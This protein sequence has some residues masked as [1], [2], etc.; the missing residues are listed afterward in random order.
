MVL[1]R[2]W[3]ANSVLA[4]HGPKDS[5][6]SCT[7]VLGVYSLNPAIEG[8][9]TQLLPATQPAPQQALPAQKYVVSS[10]S[11]SALW[12]YRRETGHPHEFFKIC[13]PSHN[14]RRL[15]RPSDTRRL[16]DL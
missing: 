12:D 7:A 16:W 1:S 9:M 5:S 13:S 3:L 11:L 14:T 4:L 8:P 6:L 15:R 2:A 10:T